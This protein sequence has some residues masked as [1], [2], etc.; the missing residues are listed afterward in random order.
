MANLSEIEVQQAIEFFQSPAGQA[1]V[2]FRLRH[3][4][5][6]L[7]AATRKEQVADEQVHYPVP[8]QKELETFG[9]T[10]AGKF[11]VGDELLTREEIRGRISDLR[12]EA[13]AKCLAAAK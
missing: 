11:F 7:D 6:L 2:A 12:S 5:A 4:Q 1:V 13:M 9:S 3:E 10:P 8:L